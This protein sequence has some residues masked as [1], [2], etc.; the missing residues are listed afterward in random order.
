MLKI[1]L[2]SNHV[3]CS[4]CEARCRQKITARGIVFRTYFNY[5]IYMSL[6]VVI[7]GLSFVC[8]CIA[9]LLIITN[10]PRIWQWKVCFSWLVHCS[11]SRQQLHLFSQA[12]VLQNFQI[13][14]LYIKFNCIFN[15][16]LK[17]RSSLLWVVT[18][19]M[20]VFV[21]WVFGTDYRSHFQDY[22][23]L[24]DVTYR[25]SQNVCKIPTY[26]A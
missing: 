24:E 4:F 9:E 14:S 25:L 23:T 19:R 10:W 5:T 26:T 20:L 7:V 17:L 13:H 3:A 8:L 21:Y 15:I 12:V 16:T 22:L 1:S 2:A 18:Q 6:V 11:V